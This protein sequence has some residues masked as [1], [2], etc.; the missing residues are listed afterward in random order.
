MAAQHKEPL[1]RLEQE[2]EAVTNRG[3]RFLASRYPLRVC[4]ASSPDYPGPER[5]WR[6]VW[7]VEVAGGE[8]P[9]RLLL[10]VPYTF[11]DALPVVYLPTGSVADATPLPHIDHNRLLCTFD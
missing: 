4:Q 11:P 10:A 6:E 7:E 1:E 2:Y 9:L 8:E 5:N 3:R